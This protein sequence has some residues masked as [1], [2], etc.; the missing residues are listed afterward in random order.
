MT[1]VQRITGAATAAKVA[2]ALLC[3]S[4]EGCS[5]AGMASCLEVV[6]DA[7]TARPSLEES[8]RLVMTG[9]EGQAYHRDTAVVVQDLFAVRRTVS[10]WRA[11]RCTRAAGS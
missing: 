7:A 2:E 9:P 6:A 3:L 1:A 8:V 11:T 4:L 10:R 5:P